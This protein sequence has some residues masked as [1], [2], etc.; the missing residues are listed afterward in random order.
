[1]PSAR[2]AWP[3]AGSAAERLRGKADPKVTLN[4]KQRRALRALGHHLDPVVIVGKEGV[5]EGLIDAAS[6]ALVDHELIKV[7]VSEGSPMDRHEA[8]EALA[9]AT[10]S[11]VA[12]VLGRT[13]LLFRRNE[14]DPKLDVPGL[15][16]PPPKEKPSS[17]PARRAA[18]KR[19]RGG[20]GHKPGSRRE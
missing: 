15:P 8:A 10:K 7:K 3:A 17:E 13:L 6:Q 4:G 5:S 16:K 12:Q 14:D 19:S 2:F 18:P 11:E 1:M 20:R 9:E